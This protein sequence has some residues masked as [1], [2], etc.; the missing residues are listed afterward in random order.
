MS[1]MDQ[2][3]N[4]VFPPVAP[5]RGGRASDHKIALVT[6]KPPAPM[7]KEWT[8]I[9]RRNYTPTA[10][11]NFEKSMNEINWAVMYTFKTVDQQA[12]F[13]HSKLSVLYDQHF[14]WKK[15]RVKVREAVYFNDHLRSLHKQMRKAY[16][17]G[18][19]LK[20][21]AK[22]RKFEYT[23]K[24][25]RAK[26][27]NGKMDETKKKDPKKYYSDLGDLMRNG[28]VR[29]R[30]CAPELLDMVGLSPQQCADRAVNSIVGITADYEAL[31]EAVEKAACPGGVP[32]QLR[33][34]D[35]VAAIKK[36]KLPKGM[37]DDDP[38]RQLLI[39]KPEVFAK[40]LAI[41][42]NRVFSSCT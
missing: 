22:K 17:G 38:P 5:D 41:I 34:E 42:Y 30:Q 35:V 13:L 8:T 6:F 4:D 19:S 3:N 24:T 27:Y 14:P 31:D 15:T 26:Y 2:I 1:N 33:E 28:G 18:N 23:L 36:M 21:R 7:Q 16:K 37:H 9:K 25:T 12:E 32:K 39:D 20:Y 29:Q 11:G 40:P 10:A